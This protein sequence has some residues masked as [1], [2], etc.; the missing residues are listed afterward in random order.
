MEGLFEGTTGSRVRVAVLAVIILLG[1]FLVAETV[2]GF[3]DLRYVGAGVQATN[4]INVSGYGEAFGAPDIAT[5]SFTVSSEKTTV[6]AAQADAT[7]KINAISAYLKK[8]GI[9]DK[10][11]RTSDYSINPQYDYTTEA[12]IAGVPCRGGTQTLRG[13]EVSQTTTIKVRDTSKAGDLLTGV[14]QNG[15]TQVSGLSFTFDDPNKLQ[16]DARASAIADAKQKADLLAKQL[17]VSL[18]RVVS[19]NDS[20]NYPTPYY[21]KDAAYSMGAG[22]ANEAA[23]PPSI[24]IGQ[25]KVTSNVNIT[26]EIR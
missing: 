10:D 13:Y 8:Q 20:G 15:A 1:L 5:F 23:T 22:V 16:N 17:G 3:M 9:D 12:C 4:T 19:Y 2:R 14:G 11:I 21:A 25:N 18:V 26:Y 24:S 7:A 6:A